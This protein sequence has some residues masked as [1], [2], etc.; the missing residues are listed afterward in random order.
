MDI[1]QSIQ[2]WVAVLTGG[3]GIKLVDAMLNARKNK[4][5]FDTDEKESLRKDIDYLRGQI[6]ELRKEVESLREQ[7]EE[8][9]REVSVW[10]RRYWSKKL[11][12]DRVIMEVEHSAPDEVKDRVRS[13][14]SEGDN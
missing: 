8:R 12:L 6:E 3:V 7:L 5:S 11:E 1:L 2:F 10:Q 9:E 14:T 13:V 4:T